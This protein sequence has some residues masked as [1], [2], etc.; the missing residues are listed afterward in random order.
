[1]AQH[2]VDQV[3]QH[4]RAAAVELAARPLPWMMRT[5]P[6]PCCVQSA[7]NSRSSDSRLQRVQAVQVELFLRRLVRRG[8]AAG[9]VSGGSRSRAVAQ[10]IAR[11]PSVCS[12][13]AAGIRRAPRLRRARAIR[14]RRPRLAA[15][16]AAAA[17]PRQPAARGPIACAEQVGVVG[18][19]RIGACVEPSGA[20]RRRAATA[21]SCGAKGAA[22][23][24][25]IMAAPPT[26]A[27]RS[28]R[29]RQKSHASSG[30]QRRRRRRPRHPRPCAGICASRPRGAV[31]APD[32]DRSGASN[33]LTLDQPM[34]V[35]AA[36]RA[37]LTAWPAR[38]P[39]A[40]TWR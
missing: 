32:R 8:A 36:R 35:D 38:R 14:A 6:M 13:S 9:S 1:M 37:D 10:R 25:A 27:V 4:R 15:R 17:A 3:L 19:R 20:R 21:S 24:S 34:R 5:Q 30:Q 28:T 33:S 29:R 23:R 31:V 18:D 7:R 22:G 12:S 11:L 39:T 2:A 40:C 16:R 26:P